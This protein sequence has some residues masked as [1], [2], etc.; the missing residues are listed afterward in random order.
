MV[1]ERG[2]TSH[3]STLIP[4]FREFA[5]KSQVE[6]ASGSLTSIEAYKRT[7]RREKGRES[8]LNNY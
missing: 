6:E 7:C 3:S 1:T 4:N 2:T 8:D 5:S